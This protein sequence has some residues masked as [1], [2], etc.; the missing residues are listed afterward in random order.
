MTQNLLKLCDQVHV[1]IKIFMLI[2]ICKKP[3]VS[4]IPLEGC[5]VQVEHL[6]IFCTG[7]Q[8]FVKRFWN[9]CG[10]KLVSEILRRA[11]STLLQKHSKK[12]VTILRIN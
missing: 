9:A 7:V 2:S 10:C 1:K 11:L 4:F 8:M 12:L 3:T 5:M 6:S